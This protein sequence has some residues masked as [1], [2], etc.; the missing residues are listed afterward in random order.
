MRAAIDDLPGEDGA[1]GAPAALT[2]VDRYYLA[3][4]E[5]Q[6]E[7]GEEPRAEQLSAYL[8]SKKGMTGRGGKPV[9]PSTLRRYLWVR[10]TIAYELLSEQDTIPA[11]S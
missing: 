10:C 7:H 4:T 8:A 1:T 6:T 9:S 2:T 5:F 3:W 11:A